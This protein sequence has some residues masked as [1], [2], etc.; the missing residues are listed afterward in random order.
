MI[1]FKPERFKDFYLE[2]QGLIQTH[3]K[4]L[5]DQS[6][7]LEVDLDQ[8]NRL[9]EAGVYFTMSARL[10]G[11]LIGYMGFFVMRHMRYKSQCVATGDVFYLDPEHRRGWTGIKMIRAAE[12]YLKS[13]GVNKVVNHVKSKTSFGRVFEFLKYKP[14]EIVYAKEL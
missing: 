8:Y 10:D 3:Y 5:S 2:A 13:Y 7:P 1:E 12:S 9:E 11:K 6:A 4:E 14:F